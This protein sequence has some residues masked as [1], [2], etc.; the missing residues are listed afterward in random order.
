MRKYLFILLIFVISSCASRKVQIEKTDI[1]KD[2]I[3][4]TKVSVVTLDNV[5]KKDSTN[6][7]INSIIDELTITPI[8][9]TR[10]IYINEIAY[11]NAVLKI[12]KTK[13]NIVYANNN[14]QSEIKLKDSTGTIVA[15][16]KEVI[17]SKIKD[18]KKEMNYSIFLWVFI[19]VLILYLIWRNRIYIM[20]KFVGV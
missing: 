3:V 12:K 20:R 11:K 4:E 19:L 10:P 16:K 13:S 6:I 5:E 17:K 1:K 18:I 15:I 8:D 2:S 14:K 9:T 7:K